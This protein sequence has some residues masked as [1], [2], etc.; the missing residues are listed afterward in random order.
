M[1]R[2]FHS[3]ESKK[4]EVAVRRKIGTRDTF[5]AVIACRLRAP[6][7]T[8]VLTDPTFRLHALSVSSLCVRL[9]SR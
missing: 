2:A 5:A 1:T 7:R 6:I 4:R 8:R 9:G 3:R